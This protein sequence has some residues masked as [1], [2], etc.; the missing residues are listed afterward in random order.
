MEHDL[1]KFEYLRTKLVKYE[2]IS[3]RIEYEIAAFLN[4]VS[5]ADISETTSTR[6]KAM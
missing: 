3:D 2:E 1:E 4:D 5:A 6:I